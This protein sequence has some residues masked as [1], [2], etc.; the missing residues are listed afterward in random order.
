MRRVVLAAALGLWLLPAASAQALSFHRDD[1]AVPGLS[2][3][4]I[5]ADFTRDG[6]LDLVG[7]GAPDSSFLR[8]KQNGK[9]ADPLAIGVGHQ[10]WDGVAG[11][12]DGDGKPDLVLA[13]NDASELG[14]LS[15]VGDGS[16][17]ELHPFEVGSAPQSPDAG[18]FD[19][20]G[21]RDVA[22][23]DNGSGN[24]SVAFGN[25]LGQFPSVG[26]HPV[27]PGGAP[28]EVEVGDFN[29]D[30]RSDVASADD[31]SNRVSILVSKANRTFRPVKVSPPLHGRPEGITSG[32]FDEDGRLDVA[33]ANYASGKVSVLL[34][35]GDGTL[36]QPRTY[37][38]I[39]NTWRIETTDL[40]GDGH[41]DLIAGNDGPDKISILRGRG[42]GTFK[43]QRGFRVG[44]PVN[45]LAIGNFD[46][47]HGPDIAVSH[48]SG[49]LTVLLNKG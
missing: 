7:V 43:K 42:D 45:G 21:N 46:H 12:F 44:G 25:G 38:A 16:F 18:D 48:D 31:V 34:G 6:R 20:D 4:V 5:A 39:D 23:A 9:F 19:G 41:L 14:F 17:S 28:Y 33:T 29:G 49:G 26:D 24:V 35:K 11:R 8:G 47:K 3:G 1:Y 27:G 37:D 30:H 32:D 13:L 10:T 15:S 36:K 40:N 22:V 2:V